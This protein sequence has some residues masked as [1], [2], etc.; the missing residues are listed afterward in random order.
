M[1]QL[2]LCTQCGATT[3]PKRVTPGSGWITFV[4]LWFFIVPGLVYWI[5][6]H[7]SSYEACSQCGSRNVIPP[8]TPVAQEMIG[9]RP[10]VAASLAQSQRQE[11]Q[12][13][14]DTRVGAIALL[15][16]VVLVLIVSKLSSCAG[17]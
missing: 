2:M 3:F 5:W 1:A 17:R 9:T 13:R 7:T 4:L 10:S 12:G 15:V 14:D 6:R 8:T 16:I 11:E